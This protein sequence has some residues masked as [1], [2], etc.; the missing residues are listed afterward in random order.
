MNNEH[1]SGEWRIEWIIQS[2]TAEIWLPAFH[3]YSQ[4]PW[5]ATPEH[6]EMEARIKHQDH[7]KMFLGINDKYIFVNGIISSIRP[8]HSARVL[9][10]SVSLGMKLSGQ[11]SS[12]VSHIG[13]HCSGSWTG[14]PQVY[15]LIRRTTK[16][17]K[18]HPPFDYPSKHKDGLLHSYNDCFSKPITLW[19]K[20]IQ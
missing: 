11:P 16:P 9:C 5:N 17:C 13:T 6:I 12:E 8:F 2:P 3:V 15:F 10:I 14:K 7:F 4:H 19:T 18:F 20:L 1:V